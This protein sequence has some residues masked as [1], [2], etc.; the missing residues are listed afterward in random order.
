MPDY[1]AMYFHLFAAMA[2][3]VEALECQKP[4]TA[5]AILIEAQRKTEEDYLSAED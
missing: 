5:K 4:E 2:E 3:A 1:K